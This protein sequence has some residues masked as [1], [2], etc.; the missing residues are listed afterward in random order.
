MPSLNP[1]I[2]A[3]FAGVVVLLGTAAS[4]A[5]NVAD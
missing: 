3:M 1:L 4:G 2:R 5:V